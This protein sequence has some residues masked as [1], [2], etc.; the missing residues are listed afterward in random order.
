MRW[1]PLSDSGIVVLVA[2]VAVVANVFELCDRKR[3]PKLA[4]AAARGTLEDLS[5]I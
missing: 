2:P 1:K 4:I 3:R 5:D